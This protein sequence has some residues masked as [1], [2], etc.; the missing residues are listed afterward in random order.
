M[1]TGEGRLVVLLRNGEG[2]RERGGVVL[3]LGWLLMWLLTKARLRRL[4]SLRCR[5]GERAER[6]RRG[7]E[8]SSAAAAEAREELRLAERHLEGREYY[9]WGEDLACRRSAREG[10]ADGR[11]HVRRGR[12]RRK[13]VL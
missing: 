7:R 12:G 10:L 3:S 1:R 9:D 8:E 13:G 2:R 5:V 6:R 11:L 4:M